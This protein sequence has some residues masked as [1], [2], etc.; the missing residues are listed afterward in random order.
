MGVGVC[1]TGEE[2]QVGSL[3]MYS[4]KRTWWG[5]DQRTEIQIPQV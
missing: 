1:L 3:V 2:F 4:L 5:A